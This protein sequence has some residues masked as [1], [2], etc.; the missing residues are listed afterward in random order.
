MRFIFIALAFLAFNACKSS[1]SEST[2]SFVENPVVAHRGA[3]KAQNLPQNSIAS[4]KRAIE[5]GCTGSEFDVRMTS[6]NVLIVTHDPDF[7]GLFI[8]DHTYAELSKHKLPNGEM[9]PTLKNYLLA[10]MEDNPGTGLVCEIK[11]SK[12]EGRNAL[13]A[14]KV[15]ELVDELKAERYISYYISF[16]Y[17][18]L[19]RIIEINPNA[20]TLY[21]DGSKSPKSLKDDGV[22]GLD[23]A[24]YIYKRKPEWI[25]SAKA[26]NL[27]LN[28]WTVNKTEDIDLFLAHDFNYI[29]TDEPELVFERIRNSA[30]YNTGYQLVWNDEFNYKGEPDTTKWVYSYGFIANQEKQYYT[31]SLK[32]AR[33]ENGHLIIEAHKEKLANK[34]YNNPNLKEWANYKKDIDSAQYSSAR[35]STEGL[36]AWTYGRIEVRAKLPKGRGMWPA[37]WMLSEDR[38]AI[39]WPESGEIDIMEHVG[40]DND[41][42]HGTIHTKAYNHLKGTQKGKTIFIDDP[43]ETFHVFALEWTPEKMDFLLDGVVYNSIINEHKTTAEWPFD[44]KFHLILNVAV[45]GMWGGL[46]GV[47]D[48]IFPQQ[49]TVDYVRVFQQKPKDL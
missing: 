33:V 45:G 22:T 15:L 43:N 5:L 40:Y 13:M 11:P 21:L 27:K 46:K 19:K 9:L 41:T 16:S 44:K 39:G 30:T 28:A 47:D 10:G 12:T 6:D 2:F 48:S 18:L 23:Y 25:E 17:E 7:N 42:I 38:K 37:I 29:T 20:K 35:L 4:L 36:A 26:N 8:E 31:D 14:E 34:D 1:K 3:W 32:N 24:A 49:M